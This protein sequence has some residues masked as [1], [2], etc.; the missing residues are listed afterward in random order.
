MEPGRYL[1]YL[2]ASQ[3]KM[4]AFFVLLLFLGLLLLLVG[5]KLAQTDVA[6]PAGAANHQLPPRPATLTARPDTLPSTPTRQSGTPTPDPTRPGQVEQGV[7]SHVV[8]YGESLGYVANMYN[9]T[10]EA[11]M[12]LN[13]LDSADN[14]NAGQTLLVPA[15]QLAI[16]PANKLIPDSELV[17]GPA[18]SHFHVP[19][20]ANKWG[21]YLLR[22]TEE[23]DG[24]ILSGPELVQVVARQYSVGPR[25]LL[26]L[27]ELKSNWITDPN[28]PESTLYYP[29]GKV[30]TGWDGLFIQLSWA[31]NQLNRGYYG[32]E[33]NWLR[34][35]VFAD[36]TQ[37]QLSPGINAGT[38]AVQTFLSLNNSV[39]AWQSQASWD[40]GF[41]KIYQS[42][43]GNP[44]QYAIE[45]LI[46][47]DLTPPEMSLPWGNGETWYLTGGPHGGWGSNSGWAALDFVPAGEQLGCYPSFEWVRAIAPGR[48]V[49]SENGQVVVDLGDDAFEGTGWA[50]LYMHIGS[51][52]R[53]PED[54]WVET[55][56]KIGHPSCEGGFSN[57]THLHIARRYNGR[58]IEADGSFPFVLDGWVPVSYASQYD[59]ALVKGDQTREACECR[60]LEF[61]GIV[62]R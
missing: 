48:V 55:G 58:W 23:L 18:F 53:V 59:G 37:V 62:K 40:G 21:G 22:Y 34:D 5:C 41:I 52:G 6:T 3:L 27:L 1:Y 28:P 60:E 10:V 31:A 7:A 35:V 38:A 49:R 50:V 19:T 33:A 29:L 4:R 16:G 51:D 47:P 57:G 46:P 56:D 20:F 9:T 11:L 8:Q 43:F 54:T 61:N 44:F 42:F 24:T 2:P 36:G 12:S 13:K 15:G 14:V 26:A 17:Y 39:P 25:L 45:P 32:W 30:G